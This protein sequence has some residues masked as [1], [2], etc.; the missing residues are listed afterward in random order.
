MLSKI[1]LKNYKAFNGVN[2]I[3]LKPITLLLGKNSSGKSS[4]TKL[5]AMLASALNG[6]KGVLLPLVVDGGIR[7]AV[8]YEDLFH[9][10][11]TSDME[12]GV[13]YDDGTDIRCS[14]LM[15]NGKL[16][17]QSYGVKGAKTDRY[18]KGFTK[19]DTTNFSGFLHTEILKE[20]EIDISNLG[21]S[22]NYLGPIREQLLPSFAY[23]GSNV[24]TSIGSKGEKAQDILLGSFIEENGLFE[25]VSDWFDSHLE[26]QKLEMI[27][28]G[29]NSGTYSLYVRRNN[30]L[31]NAVDVGQGLTQVLPVIVESFLPNSV[32]IE[33]MEQPAIHLHP[34]AH[35]QVAYRLVESAKTLNKK[36]VI[37][38]HS[39]NFL[40]ELRKIV[41]LKELD[42]TPNDIAVYYIDS[43]E[44]GSFI[45]KI[46]IDENGDLNQW[47]DG[48]FEE[49]YQ[50]LKDILEGRK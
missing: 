41:A 31:V 33:I 34:A 47:P 36:Y 49:G 29:P 5:L 20:N 37:E 17:A 24:D 30:V 16:Y 44:N 50:L 48:L 32:D 46:T 1:Y 6:K 28:N 8:K 26:G 19:E 23:S 40:L 11:F 25:K 9:N 38:S 45:E 18:E 10:H 27:S 42:V 7:I 15:D 4:I 35:A 13:R 3:E 22:V 43:D 2:E 39:K 21:F 14:Y 12:L